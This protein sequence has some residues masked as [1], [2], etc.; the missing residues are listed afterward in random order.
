MSEKL[1]PA[2]EGGF[3]EDCRVPGPDFGPGAD[4]FC[5]SSM[6]TESAFVNPAI[7]FFRSSSTS[8]IISLPSFWDIDSSS[9]DNST[10]RA[11]A[12]PPERAIWPRYWERALLG[13]STA[14]TS[15]RSLFSLNVQGVFLLKSND[16][17]MSAFF[18]FFGGVGGVGAGVTG[19][20]GGLPVG[21]FSDFV[22]LPGPAFA[23][24]V[25]LV[26]VLPCNACCRRFHCLMNRFLRRRPL[27]SQMRL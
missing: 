7:H 10:A 24:A 12:S 8:S 13:F 26:T 27:I 21:C 1:D 3:C 6:C 16:T 14:Q 18:V 25:V 2:A 17:F 22:G 9:D 11:Y 5:G 23:F 20:V 4:R 15:F 19:F